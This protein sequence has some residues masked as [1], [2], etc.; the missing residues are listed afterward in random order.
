MIDL[1][2]PARTAKIDFA[3]A[4]RQPALTVVLENIHDAHNVNA[5]LRSC[6]AV[7]VLKVHL[8]YTIESF[9]RLEL[10]S[11]SGAD[12][13][14]EY[15]RHT[16][17]EGCFAGLR[18]EGFQILATELDATARSLYDFDLTK[19]T[20]IVLGNEHRGISKEVSEMADSLVYIPMMG[21]AESLN[22]S[23]ASA[24]C[25]FEALRQRNEGGLYRA[26]QL[27]PEALRSKRLEW[28]LK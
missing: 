8:L 6:D 1:K 22:V 5:I 3:L 20:A 12:K 4:R 19:S 10:T 13:W 9:P 17:V 27:S 24:V 28:Q 11:A 23:V 14:L 25:L 26:P 21:M 7:G 15:E 16:S 18:D 2:S